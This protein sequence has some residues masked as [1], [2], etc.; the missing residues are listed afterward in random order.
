MQQA[1]G[2]LL[3]AAAVSKRHQRPTQLAERLGCAH[4]CRLHR[5]AGQSARWWMLADVGLAAIS[6]RSATVLPVQNKQRSWHTLQTE[7]RRFFTDFSSSGTNFDLHTGESGL[8]ASE[9]N[10]SRD[11]AMSEAHDSGWPCSASGP[12]SLC[13]VLQHSQVLQQDVGVVRHQLPRCGQR[14]HHC[15]P[16]TRVQVPQHSLYAKARHTGLHTE[17][18]P[19]YASWE[20]CRG[21]GRTPVTWRQC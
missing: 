7:L 8:R 21:Q 4:E 19:R 11:H 5:Q 6:S 14:A 1:R 17:L 12:A 3:H 20:T 9:H 10:V 2:R 18:A 15:R 13:R 16:V